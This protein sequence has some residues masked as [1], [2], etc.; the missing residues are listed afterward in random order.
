MI[1]VMDIEDL[2]R[3]MLH[4][5]AET[6]VLALLAGGDKHGYGIRREIADRSRQYFNLAFGRLYPMLDDLEERGLVQSRMVKVGEIRERRVYAITST[7]RKE[8]EM[9]RIKWRRFLEGMNQVLDA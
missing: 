6:L 1:S 2:D 5:N 7:G 8:L 4:G 3:K 9:R